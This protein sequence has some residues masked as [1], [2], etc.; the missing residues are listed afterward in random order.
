MQNQI[1]III[2]LIIKQQSNNNNKIN[3]K[4]NIKQFLG[5]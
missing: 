2:V 1:L 5:I 3:K 4:W